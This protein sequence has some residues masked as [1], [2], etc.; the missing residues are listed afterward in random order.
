MARALKD[1]WRIYQFRLH[2][3]QQGHIHA[4]KHA[5]RATVARHWRVK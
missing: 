4:I 5:W 2:F 3:D 1:F